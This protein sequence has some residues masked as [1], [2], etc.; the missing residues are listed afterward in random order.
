M[1]SRRRWWMC[2]K[3]LRSAALCLLLCSTSVNG[4]NGFLS[5]LFG[6]D[7]EETGVFED[8]IILVNTQHI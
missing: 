2:L 3:F 8:H 1:S 6:D 7:E 4:L 5:G